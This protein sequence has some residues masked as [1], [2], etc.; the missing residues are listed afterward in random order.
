MLALTCIF[1]GVNSL[2]FNFR[3]NRFS[4][5]F[6]ILLTGSYESKLV[7]SIWLIHSGVASPPLYFSSG[8]DVNRYLNH[9]NPEVVGE[10]GRGISR[11]SDSP[12]ANFNRKWEFRDCRRSTMDVLVFSRQEDPFML[13]SHLGQIP[14]TTVLG[15]QWTIRFSKA[16]PSQF[17]CVMAL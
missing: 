10:K 4:E 16:R 2:C 5:I 17:W 14:H 8:G 11:R 7:K 15:V 1:C 13:P 9:L 12:H 6:N 3:P